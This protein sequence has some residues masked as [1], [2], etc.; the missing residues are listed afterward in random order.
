MVVHLLIIETL[1]WYIIDMQ[2]H[3]YTICVGLA[4]PSLSPRSTVMNLSQLLV[5][6][7]VFHSVV[8]ITP[9]YTL[10][11]SSYL[12]S[13]ENLLSSSL[14]CCLFLCF[15]RNHS[16]VTQSVPMNVFGFYSRY[17]R[18]LQQSFDILA[19]IIHG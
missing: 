16:G 18:S 2:V 1:Y 19:V 8:S 9:L 4:I 15:S 13:N 6:L 14:P 11:L 17:K 5:F 10:C 3:I 12:F 7:W